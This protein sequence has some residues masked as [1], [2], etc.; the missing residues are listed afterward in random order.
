LGEEQMRTVVV[1]QEEGTLRLKGS[2]AAES[3]RQ[4]VEALAHSL[5]GVRAVDTSH[6]HVVEVTD[7]VLQPGETLWDLAV[8]LYG[9]GW[10]WPRLSELNPHLPRDLRRI[11]PG[12]V[13]KVPTRRAEGA[14]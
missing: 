13:L 7:Y 11:R 5:V 14:L 1:E 3:D 2:V 9:E 10:K 6:L 8:R 4:R 12:I